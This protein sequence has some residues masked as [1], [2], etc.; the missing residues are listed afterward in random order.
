MVGQHNNVAR[1]ERSKSDLMISKDSF[2]VQMIFKMPYVD[3]YTNS[4]A[5][6]VHVP[7]Y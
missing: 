2:V 4:C 1:D 7:R 3:I 5:G 6:L